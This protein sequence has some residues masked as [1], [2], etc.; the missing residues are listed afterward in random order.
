MFDTASTCKKYYLYSTL[1]SVIL[2]ASEL[3][4]VREEEFDS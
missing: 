2:L 1:L 3:P 4:G